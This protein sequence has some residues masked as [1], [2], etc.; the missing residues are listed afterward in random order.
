MRDALLWAAAVLPAAAL[1]GVMCTAV[2]QDY[3]ARIGA[4][5]AVDGATLRASL[6]GDAAW[7]RIRRLPRRLLVLNASLITLASLPLVLQP[8]LMAVA[9]VAACAVLLILAL[10][11]SRC[12]LLPDALTL[13]LLWGGLLLA[14][15]GVGVALHDAVFAAVAAYLFMRGLDAAFRLWR[16]HAGM[17]GGDMKLFAAQGA[18]FGW[19]PLPALLLTACIVAIIY[20][21]VV[22][23]RGGLRAPIAFGPFLALS[24]G[25]GLAG[26]PVVQ[27]LF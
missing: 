17:G 27:F 20:S 18:W 3:V 21:V 13:P 25:L 19:T 5:A 15:A 2:A 6:R 8:S 24:G 14:W 7:R 26:D 1:L 16:G 22:H 11:D 9:C 10:I 23:G 4:G 12:G